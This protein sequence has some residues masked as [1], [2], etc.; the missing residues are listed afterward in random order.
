M[1]TILAK[2]LGRQR[3]LVKESERAVALYKGEIQAILMPGEHWLA[4]RRGNL[5]ISRHDLKNPEFVSAYEKALFDK[6]PDVAA[7]HFTVARTGR[8]DVAVI[9]R[10]GALHAILAADRKLVLWT[11]AGPWKVTSVDTAADLAVDPGLMRRIGQAR[12]TEHIFVNPVVDGQVGLLFVDGVL[13]RT[14]EAGVHAFWNVG[15]M[16]QVKVVDIKRQ[17]LDVAGQEMLTKDRVTIRVNIAAEYRVV[18][19]VKAVS[20]V[21][22]FSEALYRALQYAFRKTLGA[23]TLDQILDKRVTVDEDA[24]AKVRDDM[25]AIGVEV[26]DIALKDVILPG[27]MREILNQVVAAEKQAEANVIRR[28]EETNATRSLLNTAKVMAENPVMLRLKELEALE[29]IAGKVERLTVHNGTGGLLNDLVKLR[30]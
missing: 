17:S 13:A 6:L 26:S 16:V 5:E 11:D 20:T 7:R 3:V 10:D 15:R 23:L 29:T 1:N 27:D 22:D 30:D 9:E 12:K 4:N 25:A 21:K 14:L 19:P 24:A 18:D 28:R 8:T 2:L